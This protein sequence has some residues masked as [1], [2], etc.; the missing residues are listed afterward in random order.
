MDYIEKIKKLEKDQLVTIFLRDG[1]V[2]TGFFELIDGDIDNMGSHFVMKPKT[3]NLKGVSWGWQLG[4]IREV[5]VI[6]PKY[7]IVQK[8]DCVK[9]SEAEFELPD[10][11]KRKIATLFYDG[12]NDPSKVLSHAAKKYVGKSTNY[13]E[14]IDA[15]LNC[16]WIRVII[17]GDLDLLD[18]E[19]FDENK[20]R[21]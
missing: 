19:E 5:N 8:I 16:P 3:T 1:E 15:T 9:I 13:Y 11:E 4:H 6:D 18:S 7:L 17:S 21:L 14:L 12:D 10:G 20:H 2:V